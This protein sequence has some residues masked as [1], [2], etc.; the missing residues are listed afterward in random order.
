MLKSFRRV[1]LLPAADAADDCDSFI[2]NVIANNSH[3]GLLR[4]FT[5]LGNGTSLRHFFLCSGNFLSVVQRQNLRH[6]IIIIKS[7]AFRPGSVSN[8]SSSR[9]DNISGRYVLRKHLKGWTRRK[10]L[11]NP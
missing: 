4:F 11:A 5:D 8:T 2:C 1:F 3:N 10:I 9:P 7:M 6:L